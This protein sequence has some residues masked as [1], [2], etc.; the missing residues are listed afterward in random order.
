MNIIKGIKEICDLKG[1]KISEY[2]LGG[3]YMIINNLGD[4]KD[5]LSETKDVKVI[6]IVHQDERHTNLH[7][8]WIYEDITMNSYTGSYIINTF[9]GL[10]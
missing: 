10:E 6:A 9:K 4:I 8:S 3:G 1:V 5:G 7:S 2:Y